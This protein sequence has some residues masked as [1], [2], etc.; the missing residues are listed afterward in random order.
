MGLS[1][2]SLTTG[3]VLLRLHLVPIA[4]AD[5]AACDTAANRHA[6]LADRRYINASRFALLQPT[7]YVFRQRLILSEQLLEL[8]S[9]RCLQVSVFG[10]LC[11]VLRGHECGWVGF[12]SRLQFGPE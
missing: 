1:N 3:G 11:N 6:A 4:G 7:A 8:H 12:D 9:Q 10:C 2:E 5:C